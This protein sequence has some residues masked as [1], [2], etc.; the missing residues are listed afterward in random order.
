MPRRSG[1][2]HIAGSARFMYRSKAASVCPEQVFTSAVLALAFLMVSSLCPSFGILLVLLF[3]VLIR[4]FSVLQAAE[5][6]KE[7][8]RKYLEKSGVID[9]LTKVGP[10]AAPHH[11]PHAPFSFQRLLFNPALRA[12]PQLPLASFIPLLEAPPVGSSPSPLLSSPQ[13]LVALYEE[14]EKP[15]NALDFIKQVRIASYSAAPPALVSQLT[16]SQ[17]LGAPTSGEVEKMTSES[18]D[19]KKQARLTPAPPPPPSLPLQL[20]TTFTPHATF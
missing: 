1:G 19:L 10:L 15:A 14:P 17:F 12:T 18:E 4:P 9:A 7:E 5:S 3:N 13:V 2:S 6:K 20:P 11:P 8:F 16:L